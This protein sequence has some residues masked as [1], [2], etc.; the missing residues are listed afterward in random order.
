MLLGE[1][2]IAFAIVGFVLMA[3]RSYA[4]TSFVVALGVVLLLAS[5]AALAAGQN[6]V[7][8]WPGL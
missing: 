2:L 5:V 1:L 6:P 8:P 3:L 4:R 7:V